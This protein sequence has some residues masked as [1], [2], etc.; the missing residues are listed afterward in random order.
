MIK[1]YERNK[2]KLNYSNVVRVQ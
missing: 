1:F 2:L